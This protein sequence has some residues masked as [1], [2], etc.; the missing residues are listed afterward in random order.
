MPRPPC[1][2]L[3]MPALVILR[4]VPGAISPYV[5]INLLVELQDIPGFPHVRTFTRQPKP[6]SKTLISQLDAPICHSNSPGKIHTAVGTQAAIL[7]ALS[8]KLIVVCINQGLRQC[9][10]AEG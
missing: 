3:A 6:K 10:Y 7:P 1:R 5:V 4:K 2:V 9:F 8:L